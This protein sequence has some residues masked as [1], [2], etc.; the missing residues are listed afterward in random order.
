MSKE[1]I[2]KPTPPISPSELIRVERNV[3]SESL[4]E[5]KQEYQGNPNNCLEILSKLAKAEEMKG[6]IYKC[7][8]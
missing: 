5:R 4:D 3:N 2:L 7:C 6:E 1:D 8:G